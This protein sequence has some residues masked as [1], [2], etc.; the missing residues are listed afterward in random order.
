MAKVK[1][2]VCINDFLVG[3]AQRMLANMLRYINREE[4]ELVLITLFYW[5]GKDYFYELIPPDIPVHRLS[6]KGFTDAASWARLYW[7]LRKINADVVLSNLFF[8]NTVVR[9]FKPLFRYKAIIVEHNTYVNKTKLHQIVDRVL[10][11]VTARIVAVSNTVAIFTAQQEG[12]PKE[13]FCVIHNGI[14][15][16]ALQN[17]LAAHNPADIK[18][19]LGVAPRDK[20]VLNV[21]RLTTQKNPGLLLEGFALF[22][23]RRPGY[24]LVIVGGGGKWSTTLRDRAKT[25]GIADHV[26]LVGMRKDV[27][28]FYAI[29]DFFVS[30]S[31]IEGFGIAHAEALACG[32]PVLT[33][34]TAG[35]D[36]MIR[37]GE[38]GYFI[39][40]ATPDSVVEG[41]QKMVSA[42]IVGMRAH[43][44]KSADRYSVGRMVAA[45][46]ELFRA[47]HQR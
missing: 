4:F 43:A 14:D 28:R 21:A 25:L 12:I 39:H 40:D 38:N 47:V 35:P 46:E 30:T 16:A 26:F 3:G 11:L 1:V 23:R 45:Y 13:K 37:E 24:S 9:V 19:G 20:V 36:E 17:E 15:V 10:A 41:M 8:S 42:D 29:A 5:E 22:A 32:V 6:F 31:S 2:V 7:L 34:K 33:T 44:G 18:K 27:A